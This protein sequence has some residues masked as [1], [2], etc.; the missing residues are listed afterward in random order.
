MVVVNPPPPI[1]Q[2]LHDPKGEGK[3]NMGKSGG[4]VSR[5]NTYI[6]QDNICVYIT[7]VH[8]PV[9]VE[10]SLIIVVQSYPSNTDKI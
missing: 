1:T 8:R 2:A 3:D 9:A 4:K 10:D 6:S 5:F 7:S